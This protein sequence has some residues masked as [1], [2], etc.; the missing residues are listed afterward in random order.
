MMSEKRVYH[1][2]MLGGI[3]V[4]LCGI[5]FHSWGAVA[6]GALVAGAGGLF[7]VFVHRH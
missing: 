2:C 6:V 3:A 1:Y 4:L 7:S 5:A